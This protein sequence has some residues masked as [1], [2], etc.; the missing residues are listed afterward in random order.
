MN[1]KRFNVGDIVK[2]KLLGDEHYY[3]VTD[4]I[5]FSKNE[6]DIDVDYDIV[7]IYPVLENPKIEY[8]IHEELVK[9]ADFKSKEYKVLMDYIIEERIA[10]G[11]KYTPDNIKHVVLD[12]VKK[13]KLACEKKDELMLEVGDIVNFRHDFF[14]GYIIIEVSSFDTDENTDTY[15]TITSLLPIDGK[16]ITKT[17][18][19]K[20]L[21]LIIKNNS[22]NYESILQ[23][24]F[25]T[26]KSKGYP[27]PEHIK[28]ILE[29]SKGKRHVKKVKK[30]RMNHNDIKKT[31]EDISGEIK[32]EMLIHRMNENL[33][34]LNKAI[35]LGHEEK[36]QLY[37]NTLEEIRKELMELEYF[38]L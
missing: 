23:D 11:F 27:V 6:K 19:H 32:I 29:K 16:D 10:R 14:N 18:S 22:P 21:S 25:E 35:I 28:H 12:E 38:T 34:L 15:Y 4:F 20:D 2:L 9:V 1:N 3:M 36:I 17:A 5:D 7:L 33:D 30:T 31:L 13:P 37:K 8:M 26:R 24:I